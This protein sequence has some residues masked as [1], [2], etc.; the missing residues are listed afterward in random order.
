MRKLTS[1]EPGLPYDKRELRGWQERNGLQIDG[2]WGQES[3]G[4]AVYLEAHLEKA[5]A[6]LAALQVHYE[7]ALK[8]KALLAEI[9]DK[10]AAQLS[11]RSLTWGALP[12][13]ASWFTLGAVMGVIG[14]S[15]AHYVIGL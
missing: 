8:E 2:V 9:N 6:S 11:Q 14:A 15:F 5:E 13:A 3:M 10:L 1:R 7:A 4:Q 12:S